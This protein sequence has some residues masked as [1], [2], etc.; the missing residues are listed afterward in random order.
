MTRRRSPFGSAIGHLAK[1]RAR[2]ADWRLFEGTTRERLDACA[3]YALASSR[4]GLSARAGHDGGRFARGTQHPDAPATPRV[5]LVEL[6]DG[7]RP[8]SS[9]AQQR[10]AACVLMLLEQTWGGRIRGSAHTCRARLAARLGVCEREVTRYLDLIHAAG[11]ITRHQPPRSSTS[12]RSAAGNVYAQWSARDLSLRLV[13]RLR[14]WRR[15][16]SPPAESRGSATDVGLVGPEVDALVAD[17]R[18][19]KMPPLK[20]SVPELLHPREGEGQSAAVPGQEGAQLALAAM[21]HVGRIRG[22][23]PP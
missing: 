10:L 21:E 9:L 16:P 17:L 22:R 14:Q 7:P 5:G 2:P 6:Q 13:E 12:P 3:R 4:P 1:G 20:P 15:I 23:A 11:I 8:V 19:G 18:T